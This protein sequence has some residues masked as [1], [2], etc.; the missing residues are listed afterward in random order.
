MQID[1]NT[2]DV[3]AHICKKES[4]NYVYDIEMY[5]RKEIEP[6]SPEDSLESGRSRMPNGFNTIILTEN[7]IV[8][9]GNLAPGEEG[10]AVNS[11]SDPVTY[12][13]DRGSEKLSITDM[14]PDIF[15]VKKRNPQ[16]PLLRKTRLAIYM[17]IPLNP[18]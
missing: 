18:I 6:S 4:G 16:P 10:V 3:L 5:Q 15:T 7:G 2:Y 12:H 9:K 1:G 8:K 17:G 14:I 11:N 13:D